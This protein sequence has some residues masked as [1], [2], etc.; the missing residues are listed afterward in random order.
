[1]ADTWRWD[2]TDPVDTIRGRLAVDW[3]AADVGEIIG[4]GFNA[5]GLMVKGAGTTG[6]IGV[7]IFSQA[8]KAG[9]AVDAVKRGE[10]VGG[11]N[12]VPATAAIAGRSYSIGAT[13]TKTAELDGVR[14]TLGFTA[15]L[16]RLVVD[17]QSA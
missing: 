1:M 17:F 11:V 16:D 8:Y 13:G 12:I 3:L 9:K 10:A 7:A 14:G 4:V 15:E 6:V 2:K 5:S